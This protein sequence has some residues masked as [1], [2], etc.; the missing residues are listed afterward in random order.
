MFFQ[1]IR[2][3]EYDNRSFPIPA[4][5]GSGGEEGLPEQLQ[6]DREL[7]EPPT[8]RQDKGAED[9]RRRSE[10]DLRSRAAEEKQ[11]HRTSDAGWPCPVR[12]LE[13][14]P[15]NLRSRVQTRFSFHRNLQIL[16]VQIITLSLKRINREKN[17]LALLPS[18]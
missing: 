3:K 4:E 17:G 15:H 18:F 2:L 7:E 1:K 5:N 11:T 6:V 14:L 16:F 10:G 13:L 12:W 9:G 8:R